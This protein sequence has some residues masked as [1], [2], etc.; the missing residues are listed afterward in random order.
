MQCRMQGVRMVE[1]DRAMELT[2]ADSVDFIAAPEVWDG[3]ATGSE[4]QGE[5]IDCITAACPLYGLLGW[6]T[7]RRVPEEKEG[8]HGSWLWVSR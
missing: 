6:S 4:F 1:R 7:R 3:T 2:T 5:G 8:A